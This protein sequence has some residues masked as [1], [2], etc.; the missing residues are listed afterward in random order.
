MKPEIVIAAPETLGHVFAERFAALARPAITAAGH[1]SCALPGGSV[2]EAFFPPLARTSVAWDAVEFFWGDERAVGPDNPDSN[3]GLAKRLLLD[4][5]GADPRRVH[6]V[7]TEGGD[8]EAAARA[9]QEDL[10]RVLGDPPHIDVVVL[11]VG[12]EGHICSLF[13]GHALLRERVRLVAAITDSPKP[14]PRRI[15]FTMLPLELARTI[16][17]AGFGE[18]KAHAIREAVERPDSEMPVALALRAAQQALVLVDPAA[19]SL[20]RARA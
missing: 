16:C 18:S 7:V 20:L 3:Y 12:P 8:L 14:P 4:P 17:I 6:R 5:V 11:G 13:P 19:A 9:Y 2:A 15:T 10:R 1:F